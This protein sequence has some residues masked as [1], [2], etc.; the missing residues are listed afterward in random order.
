M[1]APEGG[2]GP[3]V[4]DLRDPQIWIDPHPVL[5]AARAA[6]RT[7]VT[8]TGEVVLLSADDI[9]TVLADPEEGFTEPM[10][11]EARQRAESSIV[12]L[13]AYVKALLAKRE[14]DPRDDVISMLA[15]DGGGAAE[16]GAGGGAEGGAGSGSGAIDPD[17]RLALVVNLIG[18]AVGSSRAVIVNSVLALVRHPVQADRLRADR[19]LL[20]GAIE[21]CLRLHPPFRVGRRK[22]VEPV[23]A[24]GLSLPAGST[25]FFVRASA[26]R[27][28]ARFERPDELDI[29]RPEARHL[30]FGHG[31]HFCLAP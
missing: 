8:H 6:G 10:T 31:P 3:V 27:D 14:A 4:I 20:R 28:P 5:R 15:A 13:Y 18:G 26:N 17:D 19:A 21:E 9:E 23:E 16:A 1:T 12:A 30:S 11:P 2:T 24:F 22:T 7:A 29:S 25:V